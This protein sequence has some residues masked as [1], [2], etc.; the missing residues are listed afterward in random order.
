MRNG[1]NLE[2]GPARAATWPGMAPAENGAHGPAKAAM[3]P[4]HRWASPGVR[5]P[6]RGRSGAGVRSC[7][8][9][10]AHGGGAAGPEVTLR[11]L[12]DE[13]DLTEGRRARPA[14]R[15]GRWITGTARR[16]RRRILLAL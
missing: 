15:G 8:R 14:R 10:R 5:W 16:R 13:K 6:G 9:G 4:T 11:W 1:P 2:H 3:G 7:S 12:S